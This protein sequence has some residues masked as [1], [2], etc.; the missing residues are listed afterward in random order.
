MESGMTDQTLDAGERQFSSITEEGLDALR[1]LVGVRITDTLEPWCSEVTRDSVRHYA[2]GIGDDNPLWCDPAYAAKTRYGKIIAPP[3]FVFTLNRVFSGYVGGLPGVHA[4]WSG[5]DTTWIRPLEVGDDI[6]TVAYLKD[7]IPHETRFAGLAIQQIYHVDFYANGEELVASGDSWCFRTERDAARELGTKYD[8]VKDD[9]AFRVTNEQL[10]RVAAA[11][12]AERPRGD[13]PLYLEDVRVGDKL[14]SMVKGPMTV[15]GF[16]AFA[17]GWGGLYIRANRLAHKQVRKH[18]G[19]GIPNR[20]GI[21][22]VPERVHWDDDLARRVGTPR[23]YDYGPE[24]TSWLLHQLTDWMGDGG[25]V[26][27]H[28]AQIRRHNVVGDIIDIQA[29]ITAIVNDEDGS[30]VEVKQS[31]KNQDGELSATGVGL[32]RLPLRSATGA[33]SADAT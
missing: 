17:Q 22:D 4:M 1:R 6:T 9:S 23:A 19:L 18:P 15:T 8:D 32:V 2:H 11:Y 7:L 28:H 24:R 5:A 16:I 10:E 14:P 3:S 27:K 12:D 30:L 33:G 13:E 31:A 25:F 20:Y 21:P 29:E 26:V